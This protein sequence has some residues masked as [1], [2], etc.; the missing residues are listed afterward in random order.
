MKLSISNIAWPAEHDPEMYSFISEHRFS[1]VEI[2]PT[3]VFGNKPY[4]QLGT[5]DDF[6]RMLKK[7]YDLRVS[8]L[9][10]IW[11]GLKESMFGAESERATLSDYTKQAV[12][13]AKTLGC[14]NL[15]FGCP[16]NRSIPG[17]EFIPIAIDFFREVG[18]FAGTRGVILAIEPNP[19]IYH[20]NFIN[21][22]TEAFEICRQINHPAVKVNIDLGT[23]IYYDERL[24]FIH[25]QLEL[26][27]HIHISE[28]MLEVIQER[29]IHK[30]LFRLD[31]SKWIS[32][33]M[34]DPGC[35]DAVKTVI[36]YIES[37][38]YAA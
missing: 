32:I 1:G 13:F 4:Q 35:L 29:P 18:Y 38:A 34:K 9:Q 33:E 25:D 12:V 26:V 37:C 10:S 30:E 17:V 19:P 5:A 16:K 22:T 8:S 28:P 20:T 2:A 7:Q 31:Y 27:N 15:V 21:T 3:R 14:D 24:D 23:M 6:R 36:S 11:Y